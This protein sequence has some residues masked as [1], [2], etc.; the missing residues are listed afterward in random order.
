[1]WEPR[2]SCVIPM[3]R[4]RRRLAWI[5]DWN[6][7]MRA[8]VLASTFSLFAGLTTGCLQSYGTAGE[9]ADMAQASGSDDPNHPAAPPIGDPSPPEAPADLAGS[10]AIDGFV[11]TGTASVTLDSATATL[12]LNEKKP[13]TITING[14]GASGTA[15]FALLGA[16]AGVTATF[17][18]ATVTVGASPVTTVMTVSA[19]SDMD[20]IANVAGMVQVTIGSAPNTTTFGMTVLPELVVVIPTGVD[21][22]NNNPLVFGAATIPVKLIGTGTKITFVNQ[23]GIQH[24]IHSDGTGGLDHQPNNMAANGGTYV[25]TLTEV[26]AINF[27]CHIHGKMKGNIMVK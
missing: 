6:R 2:K 10:V 8:I 18:P 23:D 21:I 19:A 16:P 9:P 1:M 7:A 14:N 24:R 17:N 13:I 25:D 11:S 12:R 15:S 27:V 22:A 20:P 3:G 4:D 5:V 26:G